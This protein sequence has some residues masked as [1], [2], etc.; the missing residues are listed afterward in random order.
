MTELI[1]LVSQKKEFVIETKYDDVSG[2]PKL[3][4]ILFAH[5]FK[6]HIILVETLYLPEFDLCLH[7]QIESLFSIILSPSNE[8]RSWNDIKMELKFFLGC[9]IFS[10]SQIEKIHVV[11]MQH[12]FQVWF[13]KNFANIELNYVPSNNWTLEMAIAF[14]FQQY[15]DTSHSKSRDWNIGLFAQ[16]D[17]DCDEGFIYS[18]PLI[19]NLLEDN[20]RRSILGKYAVQECMAVNK[21]AALLQNDWTRKHG[22]NYLKKYYNNS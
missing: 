22:E 6:L 7:Y 18:D 12:K 17:T 14:L 21:I 11:N 1:K 10:L 19:F 9:S 16:F 20:R 15:L 4:Q 3:I 5:K 13:R 2:C 8:I